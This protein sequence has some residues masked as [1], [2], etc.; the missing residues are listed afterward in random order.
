MLFC[1]AAEYM[2]VYL[3]AGIK[4]NNKLLQFPLLEAEPDLIVLFL[5]QPLAEL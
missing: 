5:V 4:L 2:E 1:A 3:G